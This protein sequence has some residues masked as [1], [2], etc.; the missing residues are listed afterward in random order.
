MNKRMLMLIVALLLAGLQ[1]ITTGANPDE[2]RT[3]AG[4][5]LSSDRE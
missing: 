5:I 2:R 1:T 4:Q 3:A